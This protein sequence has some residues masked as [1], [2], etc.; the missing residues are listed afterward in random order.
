MKALFTSE[1]WI[2]LYETVLNWTIEELPAILLLILGFFIILR[3]TRFVSKKVKSG[4]LKRLRKDTSPGEEE[5]EKRVVTLLGI[6]KAVI[7]I[8]L[9]SIFI[10]MFLNY[11]GVETGP[12]LASAGILGL[13]VGFGAQELV[14][15]FISGFFIILEN[16]IRVGDYVVINGQS[17]EVQ[18]IELRTV[19]LRDLSGAVHVFQNGKTD[20]ITNLTK[21]WS[22]IVLKIGV[23]Y[24]ENIDHIFRLM[25]KSAELL[26]EKPEYKT[27]VTKPL[28]IMGLDD[29]ADSSMIIKARLTT[30]PGQQW[31]VGRA[32][33]KILK[34]LFD[35]EN[36]EIPFPHIT[37]YHGDK[38]REES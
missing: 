1:T 21:G 19:T 9:W 38:A 12:L 7:K 8:V 4:I 25:E 33:R 36:V 10:L 3:I 35:A 2:N 15:D 27:M 22:S 30:I 6:I 32:Y 13:A 37:L 26:A 24:K 28:E 34:E 29:F 5:T 14:R 18:K 23:A 20:T 31:V 16:Q 17:G 11:I